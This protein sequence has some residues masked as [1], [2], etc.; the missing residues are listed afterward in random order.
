[1]D[2]IERS[3]KKKI[4][5]WDSKINFKNIIFSY[6]I[7]HLRRLLML[8][9]REEV[10]P[11]AAPFCVRTPRAAAS[12]F[13]VVS[14]CCS[15]SPAHA[16]QGPVLAQKNSFLCSNAMHVLF[17]PSASFLRS[18]SCRSKPLLLSNFNPTWPLIWIFLFFPHEEA[19]P[20]PSNNFSCALNAWSPFSF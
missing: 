13:H 8:F 4:K 3:K 6:F 15:K 5:N 14:W 10:L 12:C 2:E 9:P 16:R 18:S 1:M 11:Q 20:A 17:I 19:I 7:S